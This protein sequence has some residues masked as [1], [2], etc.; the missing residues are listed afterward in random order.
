MPETTSTTR[1]LLTNGEIAKIVLFAAYTVLVDQADE[2]PAGEARRTYPWLFVALAYSIRHF[3]N[4]SITLR[5]DDVA[6]FSQVIAHREGGRGWASGESV[7]QNFY[8]MDL[9]IRVTQNRQ[10]VLFNVELM[11][12]RHGVPDSI[13][14]RATL[15]L[16]DEVV[17]PRTNADGLV[18]K[19]EDLHHIDR[20]LRRNFDD[21]SVIHS[22]RTAISAVLARETV[23]VI[24]SHPYYFGLAPQTLTIQW[25][26]GG[27]VAHR[28]GC[29][30][31]Y[32]FR[33]PGVFHPHILRRGAEPEPFPFQIEVVR[34]E[35][36]RERLQAAL[37]S[38]VKLDRKQ[39]QARRIETSVKRTA[40]KRRRPRAAE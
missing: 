26:D 36:L 14:L 21:L 2:L 40:S 29:P 39:R 23:P 8:K 3:G 32:I 22:G 27:T 1:A 7:R 18:F 16:N 24:A 13:L 10:A 19:G 17:E 4:A 30:I 20:H 25:G 35:T 6:E 12:R 33:K 9:P 38:A 11:P 34:R 37:R 5:L 15:L 31:V 28:K